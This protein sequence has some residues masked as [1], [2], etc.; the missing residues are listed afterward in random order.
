MEDYCKGGITMDILNNIKKTTQIIEEKASKGI[1]TAKLDLKRMS[2]KNKLNAIYKEIG[3]YIYTCKNS[4]SEFN[5]HKLDMLCTEADTLKDTIKGLERQISSIKNNQKSSD[6]SQKT[7]PTHIYSK[8]DKKEN[9]L[10]LIKTEE[11]IKFIKICPDCSS[12]NPP[13]AV[14]CFNCS[15]KFKEI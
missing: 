5:S 2:C 15:H 13:E 14:E 8:L 6:N 4:H 12:I 7:S 10:K 11:G 3:Q 9:D 1:N